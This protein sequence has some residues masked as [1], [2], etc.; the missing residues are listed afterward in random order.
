MAARKSSVPIVNPRNLPK[1]P[2]LPVWIEQIEGRINLF[3]V[4]PSLFYPQFLAELSQ[5]RLSHP[6][7][8]KAPTQF[9]ME[10]AFGCMKLDFDR[11][12]LTSR[13]IVPGRSVERLVRSDDGRKGT[14][15]IGALPVGPVDWA[16]LGIAERSRYI[17]EAYRAIR[18]G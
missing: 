6:V 13:A 10:R 18:G 4:D 7:N 9:D 11:A 1:P 8:P 16:K 5:V 3:A 17:R 14:W 12:V 2:D 15:R